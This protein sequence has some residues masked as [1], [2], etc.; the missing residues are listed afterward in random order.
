MKTTTKIRWLLLLVTIGLFATALTARWASTRSLKLEQFAEKITDD[1]NKKERIIY[2]Y[3]NNRTNF[4]KLKTLNID[5]DLAL[6]TIN[7][8]ASRKIYFQI[9]KNNE[10]TFWSDTRISDKYAGNLKE[11]TGFIG[12]KNGWY[13]VVKK[14]DNSFSVVFYVLVKANYPFHNQFLNKTSGDDVIGDKSIDI[15][16]VSDN[17]T[18]N[19]ITQDGKYLFS[20]KKTDEVNERPNSDVE[21]FFWL[22]GFLTLSVLVNSLCKYYADEGHPLKASLA[23]MAIFAT[24]RYCC[25]HYGFP[26]ALESLKLFSPLIYAS[27]NLA[28]SLGDL[29]L[30]FF[31]AL[32]CIIFIYS[33]KHEIYRPIKNKAIGYAVLIISALLITYIAY[34]LSSIFWGLVYNSVINF[35]VA[36]LINLDIW[37]TIW[38]LV[39]LM[40]LLLFYLIVEFLV[41]LTVYINISIRKKLLFSFLFLIILNIWQVSVEGFSVYSLLLFIFVMIVA[42]TVYQYKGVII[43]PALVLITLIFSTIVALKLNTYKRDKEREYRKLLAFKLE[44]ADDSKNLFLFKKIERNIGNDLLLKNFFVQN[45]NAK[46]LRRYFL[47]EYLRGE[48]RSFEIKILPFDAN[49]E[50]FDENIKEQLGNYRN[51]VENGSL[52]VT[53]NFYRVSNTF[54][55]QNYFAIIPI[56]DTFRSLGYLVVELKY[57]QGKNLGNFP[58]LLQDGRLFSDQDYE[59]YSYAFY[60]NNKL[61]YQSGTYVYSLI[62]EKPRSTEFSAFKKDG[63]SHLVY[64]PSLSKI[65][66]VSKEIDTFWKELATLSFF[67]IIILIFGLLVLSYKWSWNL[68]SSY[69][70]SISNFK[71]RLQLTSNKMLYK[72]R[73]QIA[74]VLAVV[75]S[76]IIVGLITFSY[77][78]IQYKEQQEAVIRERVRSI[79]KA[80][81]T[82]IN[83]K[84]IHALDTY[85][86]TE[87]FKE[88]SKMYNTDL[89]LYDANGIVI[90]STQPKIYDLGIITN[91]MNPVALINMSMRQKSEFLQE[92]NIGNLFYVSAYIPIF[93]SFNNV[94]GYLQLPYFSNDNEF[95]QKISS[96]LNLLIN[97]YVLVFVAIGFFAFVVANQI[98]SPLT[99]I[100]ENMSKMKIGKKNKPIYWPRNDEIGNL[101][102]EYNKM[103][104]A[105]EES[106]NKLA[107]S[108][109][110][111]AWREMAK[112][113]AHEIKNPLTPLRLG[114]QMLERAW[115]EQDPNFDLKFQKFSKSF[116]EQ[117]DSLSRIASEFSSFAKMP[118]LKMEKIELVEVLN[119]AIQVYKQMDHI[120]IFCNEEKI[121]GVFIKADKDQ[122]LRSFNNLLKNAIEAMPEDKEG[123]VTI[124]CDVNDSFVEIDFEDNG[125]GIPDDLK[126]KIFTPNFTTKSSGTGLGLAFVKQAI[127]NIGGNIYFTTEFNEGTTF[128]ISLPVAN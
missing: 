71:L 96:F 102:S 66:I 95:N 76:L 40:A 105:L 118:D 113:V 7:Y 38:I 123:I 81:E 49:G 34:Q 116:I 122:L 6:K 17:H 64:Q 41:G 109:R 93:N 47:D 85:T 67:F 27:S 19:V 43:F 1:L 88:L 23:L 83:E 78:S 101:I 20:I 12:Y 68:I 84:H 63:F 30:N 57:K 58:L 44:S 8:F 98:T 50:S 87:S 5:A 103:L 86:D 115:K 70:F 4:D 18:A 35:K 124:H 89:N 117:I 119:Q 9:F 22:L 74:L 15:A 29:V 48:L 73:I 56:K 21:I 80:F 77:I 24:I 16:D 90:S 125:T 37:N 14:G 54:G 13:Q 91:R 75:T 61:V 10:L 55:T 42:L 53:G 92:E 45:K 107:R 99:L 121:K 26:E 108:E 60:R 65:I 120:Q 79:A 46:E 59:G 94:I 39:L 112:Q 25:L 72:T 97:I 36:N 11:G 114:I 32:W 69:K 100:Q 110:E 126:A 28:P 2:D 127:V 3:V 104:L 51:L 128:H 82:R 62:Y 106:A 52:K 33:Y 31:V 111:T